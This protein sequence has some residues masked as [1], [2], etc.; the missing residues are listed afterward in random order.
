MFILSDVFCACAHINIHI[1]HA[2]I[3]RVYKMYECKYVC[4]DIYIYIYFYK[5]N[6]YTDVVNIKI[7]KEIDNLHTGIMSFKMLKMAH[8]W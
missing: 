4:M 5:Y 2:C 8:I 3:I 6:I 1:Q 7:S